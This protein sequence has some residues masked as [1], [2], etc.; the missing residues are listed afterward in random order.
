MEADGLLVS[1]Q[2]P[3]G[4]AE[5]IQ[6]TLPLVEVRDAFKN[7]NVTNVISGFDPHPLI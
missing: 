7:K 2:L 6:E 5:V 1:A 3:A 4:V